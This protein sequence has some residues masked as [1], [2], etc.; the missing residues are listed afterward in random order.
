[1]DKN[2][3]VLIYEVGGAKMLA[4]VLREYGNTKGASKK[5]RRP[6]VVNTAATAHAGPRRT[7][8]PSRPDSFTAK[9]L[10]I[11]VN[12]KMVLDIPKNV[13]PAKFATNWSGRI[14]HASTHGAKFSFSTSREN[15]KL[16]ITRVA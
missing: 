11:G 15:R 8:S 12:R 7:L 2:L 14:S 6:K 16:T 4:D 3:I 1:M 5:N 10:N 13:D 9:L